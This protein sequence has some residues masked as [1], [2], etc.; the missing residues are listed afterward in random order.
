LAP[1]ERGAVERSET[2]GENLS[3]LFSPSVMTAGHATSLCEGGNKIITDTQ[4]KTGLLSEAR[5]LL[6]I[7]GEKL[8]MESSVYL[9][10]ASGKSAS[11]GAV[12]YL[13]VDEFRDSTA[14]IRRLQR[15]SGAW[16]W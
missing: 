6:F 14:D 5:F 3:L 4:T 13:H 11:E 12:Y 1:S 15:S 9:A 2:G 10:A 7:R 16:I 8:T